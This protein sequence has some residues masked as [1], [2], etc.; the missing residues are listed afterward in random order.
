V[1]VTAAMPREDEAPAGM[2]AEAHERG[3][4]PPV[5]RTLEGQMTARM[6]RDGE[7]GSP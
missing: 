6:V 1:F 2:L 4:S 7:E 3:V 5:G